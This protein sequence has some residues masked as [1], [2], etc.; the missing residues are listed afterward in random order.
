MKISDITNN[1]KPTQIT[2]N[3]FISTGIN[4]VD[5]LTGN[6]SAGDIMVVSG[7]CKTAFCVATALHSAM[8][9]KTKVLYLTSSNP[10]LVTR[11]LISAY[12]KEPLSTDV[13]YFKGDQ[14]NAS[15]RSAITKLDDLPLYIEPTEGTETIEMDDIAN[16]CKLEEL[17]QHYAY[18]EPSEE[19]KGMDPLEVFTRDISP[20]LLIIDS[21]DSI[22]QYYPVIKGNSSKGSEVLFQYLKKLKGMVN[23]H[24]AAVI[25]SASGQYTED[26]SGHQT[27]TNELAFCAPL[28]KSLL[29]LNF[30]PDYPDNRKVQLSVLKNA[31]GLSGAYTLGWNRRIA[32]IENLTSSPPVANKQ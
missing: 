29:L 31:D 11:R 20:W 1:Y 22:Y 18:V 25:I 30:E 16:P 32:M 14:A 26:G 5:A 13:S 4:D 10:S 23:K 27:M 21:I 7:A 2:K 9:N 12:S 19:T 15:I 28:A 3:A 6:L 8:H 17:L 24:H